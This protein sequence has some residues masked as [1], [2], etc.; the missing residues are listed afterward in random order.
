MARGREP[1]SD[2]NRRSRGRSGFS[3]II[4]YALFTAYWVFRGWLVYREHYREADWTPTDDIV[5]NLRGHR[6]GQFGLIVL[7]VFLTMATFGSAL[8][9]STVDQNIQSPYAEENQIQYL[10][11]RKEPSKRCSPATPTSTRSPRERSRP[12]SG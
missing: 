9:P 10:Y 3:L 6:W 8:A 11:Q 2:S 1:S 4:A 7:I 5:D 12:T